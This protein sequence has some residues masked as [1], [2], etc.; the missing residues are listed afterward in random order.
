V[1]AAERSAALLRKLDA[2]LHR[3]DL[4]HAPH[5]TGG[6]LVTQKG[7]SVTVTR[8]ETCGA[9]VSVRHGAS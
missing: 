3:N 7:Y 6:P 9:L 4:R 2:G 8:C 1:T 5:C